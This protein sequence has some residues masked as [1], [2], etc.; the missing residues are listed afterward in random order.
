MRSGSAIPVGSRKVE[1]HCVL[2][3]RVCGVVAAAGGQ[4]FGARGLEVAREVV[5]VVGAVAVA[6][7]ARGDVAVG[8]VG[9]R[10]AKRT[11]LGLAERCVLQTPSVV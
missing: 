5:G 10:R 3:V 11:R 7:G 4:A 6:V 2:M 8:V 1:C 9:E